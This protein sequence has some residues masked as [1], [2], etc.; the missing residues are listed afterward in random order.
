MEP[1]WVIE[2]SF[3]VDDESIFKRYLHDDARM[4]FPG[5]GILDR[6]SVLENLQGIPRWTEVEMNDCAA[7]EA[8][9]VIFLAYLAQARRTDVQRYRAYCGSTYIR[10][11]NNGS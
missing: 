3:W 10:K 6:I 11:E 1:I 9:D 7:V 2:R 4:I 8:G 5:M